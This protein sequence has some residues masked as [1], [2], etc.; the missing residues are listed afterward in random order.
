MKDSTVLGLSLACCFS[1]TKP[2]PSCRQVKALQNFQN[3]SDFVFLCRH[4]FEAY[5]HLIS[6]KKLDDNNDS[7]DD[8]IIIWLSESYIFI[9]VIPISWTGC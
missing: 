1:E 4:H 6:K 5:N 3:I 2:I 9:K 7:E 8:E